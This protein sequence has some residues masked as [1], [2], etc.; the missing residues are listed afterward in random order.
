[1]RLYNL[2]VLIFGVS[3]PILCLAEEPATKTV[4]DASSSATLPEKETAA[5][6]EDYLFNVESIS[7]EPEAH[8]EKWEFHGF[9]E[10]IS[11]LHGRDDESQQPSV[12]FLEENELTL[13]IG[14]RITRNLSFTSE[15]EIVEGFQKYGLEIF[16]FDYEIVD[17]WLIFRAGKFKYPLG[18]E[19]FVEDGPLDKLVDRPLPSIR[20]IPGTYSDIGGMLHGTI[21]MPFDTKMKYE[22]ALTNGLEG[23]N[24]ED[25]Q[26]LWDNNSNKTIGGRLGYEFLRGLE[27]GGSYSRGKYDEDNQYDIDFLAADIQFKRGNLEARGEY[28]TSHVE[29]A[30]SVGSDYNRNGYYLQTSYKYPV[31]INYFR[32][33]EGVLRFDS[34]DPNR[35]VTDGK[36]ADRVAF[37]INYSPMEHVQFKFEHEVEN[38]PGE[39]VHG[40]SFVQA[41]FRW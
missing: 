21:P 13:W 4:T 27:M 1:M 39:P 37:G 29:Q 31:D 5:M 6:P 10:S 36:E 9:F 34:V 8:W 41:I 30:S 16:E 23:P 2:F 15:V 26:Q 24:H 19:R 35:N 17:K 12:K 14:K 7:D 3:L 18:I 32:Y 28:I 25:V 11:P 33:V 38:E 40:K 22:L 20:I